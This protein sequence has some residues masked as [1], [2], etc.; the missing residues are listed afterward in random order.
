MIKHKSMVLRGALIVAALT[1]VT[2][3]SHAAP[4][5]NRG[6]KTGQPKQAKRR[7]TNGRSPAIQR[8]AQELNLTQAQQARIEPILRGT[9]KQMRAVRSDKSL[10]REQKGARMRQIQAAAVN[11]INPILNAQQ[12]KKFASILQQ[13]RQRRPAQ[14]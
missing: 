11:R 9:M 4:A 5:Q 13:M 12:R 7:A 2:P 14:R 6:H 3:I 10:S 1:L 8:L